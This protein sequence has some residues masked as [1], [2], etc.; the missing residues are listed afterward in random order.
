MRNQNTNPLVF[1]PYQQH[2]QQQQQSQQIVG[3]SPGANNGLPSKSH[4]STPSHSSRILTPSNSFDSK[5]N[6]QINNASSAT[7]TTGI[8]PG[9]AM[10]QMSAEAARLFQT[11]Q[12]SPLPIATHDVI[13]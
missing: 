7:T 8:A 13:I 5:S 6:S 9:F 4:L 12:Q 11:L 3:T 1:D 2:M 10:Y